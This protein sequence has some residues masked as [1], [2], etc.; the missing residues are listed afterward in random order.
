MA[1]IKA[2]RRVWAQAQAIISEGIAPILASWP[3]EKEDG[4]TDEE[5]S[6]RSIRRRM[7]EIERLL[8]R[9]LD[10]RSLRLLIGRT[11]ERV[12]Q[13]TKREVSRVLEIDLV[14]SDPQV[15][16][17]LKVWRE[18]NVG[19]IETGIMGH[20]SAKRL[21]P[22]LLADIS[23]TIEVAHRKGTRVEVLARRIAERFG[24]SNSRAELIA[25][26]QVLK[27]NGQITSQRQQSAG[28]TH[29]RWS[30]SQD[31]R[32]RDTHRELD[33]L[34]FP[35]ASPPEV[36]PGRHEHPGGDFQCRCVAIPVMP[37]D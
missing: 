35:W 18:H 1:Y 33:T 21:R 31:E 34:I 16:R 15:S 12:N 5:F 29:Y 23:N 27:L 8:G 2:V 30:T 10:R 25:R 22:S 26:D 11:G 24:V 13:W 9:L 6:L 36:A 3:T 4:R 37:G 32:V 17:Y 19:L 7:L 28:V 14:K 20:E